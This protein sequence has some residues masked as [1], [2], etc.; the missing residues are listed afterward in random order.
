MSE[1]IAAHGHVAVN[2]RYWDEE[3]AT[4]FGPLA[5]DH[6]AAPHPRWGQWSIPE[7]QAAMFP[8]DITGRAAIELGCGTGYVSAWLARAGA[9]PVGVDVS[10][11]QLATARAMQREFGPDFPLLLGDAEQVPCGDASFD[12]VI[13][14]YGASLWCDPNRWIPAAARLLRPGGR[15]VFLRPSPLLALCEPG[16]GQAGTT[17]RRAQFGLKALDWRE[18]G[19]AVEFTLA[20]G[21]MLRLLRDQGFVV[22]DLI[23]LQA[24]DNAGPGF[25]TSSSA[26]WAHNRPSE[27]IWKARLVAGA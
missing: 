5:R 4:Y 9:R 25:S 17:L 3:A 20:H 19:G 13:S 12:L 2:R 27:E 14:E 6:W 15:L 7:A 26:Q 11:S 21:D 22:E 10:R 24:P 16:E 1:A 23:E 8:D 18:V